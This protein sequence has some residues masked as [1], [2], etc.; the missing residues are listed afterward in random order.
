MDIDKRESVKGNKE[1][2]LDD[3]MTYAWR[4]LSLSEVALERARDGM[5]R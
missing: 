5:G 1:K 2:K 4:R 3:K